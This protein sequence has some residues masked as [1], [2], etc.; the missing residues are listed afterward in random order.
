MRMPLALAALAATLA[1][2]LV[3]TRAAPAA[4][5]Q[6][7]LAQYAADT[8]RSFDMM[9][10]PETGLVADNVSAE[11]VRARYTSPTNVGTYLWSTI[12]ARDLGL[13]TN[14]QAVAR[15]DR[16]LDTV[17]TLERHEASGQF[18]NWYDPQT[19]QKL[20]TWPVDGSTVHP[21]LSSVDNGWLAAALVM[22]AN[23]VPEHAAQARA[24]Y[25]S[26]DFGFYYDPNAGL[27][28]GGAWPDQPPGCSVY[29]PAKDVYYTCHHYGAFNSEPRI[30]SYIGIATGHIPAEHYFG[31]WRTFPADSCDWSWSEQGGIGEWR[32]YLG[33][34]VWE[35][36]YAYNDTYLVPTWGGSMFE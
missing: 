29:D 14:A 36:A 8:W 17:S 27:I 33:V 2:A 28:R 23:A 21:F 19:G 12:A 9:L 26:M 32:E 25:E 7:T 16:T 30:A 11:G 15:I 22:V 31:P 13:I 35:G 3:A 18:Y 5:P 6:Q 34:R 4:S 10:Y 24:L 1:V 20:T